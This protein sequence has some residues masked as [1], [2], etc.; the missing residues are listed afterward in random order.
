M[1]DASLLQVF[2][3]THEKA[4]LEDMDDYF[5]RKFHPLVPMFMIGRSYAMEPE[6]KPSETLYDLWKDLACHDTT[7]TSWSDCVVPLVEVG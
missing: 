5:A 7:C 2:V 6:C 1:P 3:I 4:R